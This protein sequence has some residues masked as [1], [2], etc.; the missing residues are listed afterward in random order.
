VSDR[1]PEVE[2][3]DSEVEAERLVARRID[4]VDDEGV[5]RMTIAGQLP[6]PVIDGIAYKRNATVSGI[7]LRDDEGNERGGFGFHEKFGGPILALDHV[8]G[9]A[10]GFAVRK[11]GT[12]FMF[13]GE[14]GEVK[15]EP[16]LDNRIVPGGKAPSNMEFQ[17]D[18]NGNQTINLTDQ[19]GRPRLQL[20]ISQKGH[21]EIR[22]LDENGEVTDTLAPDGD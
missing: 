12:S 1:S 5:I 11:N 21:G 22:F 9:E 17:I 15:R 19:K 8:S 16:A 20:A 4:I 6:E 7:M 3:A 10:A 13:L 14:K 18:E 2:V